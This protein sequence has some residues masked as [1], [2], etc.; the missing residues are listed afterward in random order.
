MQHVIMAH[1]ATAVLMVEE[2]PQ[3]E[4][5]TCCVGHSVDPADGL[6]NVLDPLSPLLALLVPAVGLGDIHIHGHLS[7]SLLSK[8]PV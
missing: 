6:A 8:L 5:I 1:L 2:H 4:H 7:H 3:V